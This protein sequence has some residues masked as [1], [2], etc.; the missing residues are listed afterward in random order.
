MDNLPQQLRE[1]KQLLIAIRL[2]P[3]QR[4]EIIVLLERA[5]QKIEQQEIDLSEAI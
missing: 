4:A 1:A 3:S 5:A 2:S